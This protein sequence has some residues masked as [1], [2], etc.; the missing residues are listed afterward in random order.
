[1]SFT[2]KW[3]SKYWCCNR[4]IALVSLYASQFPQMDKLLD[5]PRRF[6]MG[7]LKLGLVEEIAVGDSSI[8]I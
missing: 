5:S 2:E 8:D 1:M 6:A 7:R 4:E 3:V